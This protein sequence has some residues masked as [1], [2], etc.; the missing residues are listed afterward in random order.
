[1][2]LY[3]LHPGYAL[4]LLLLLCAHTSHC[5]G[6]TVCCLCSRST[7][8]QGSSYLPSHM[9]RWNSLN[10]MAGQCWLLLV[11]SAM[12]SGASHTTPDSPPSSCSSGLEACV[13]SC[14]AAADRAQHAGSAVYG[15]E[16][17]FGNVLHARFAPCLLRPVAVLVILCFRRQPEL[18][19]ARHVLTCC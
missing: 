11:V 3:I 10:T 2:I 16:R 14:A 8:A 19:L 15:M 18:M 5:T 6:S 9:L 4:V 17:V 12:S 13:R 7:G 1:V